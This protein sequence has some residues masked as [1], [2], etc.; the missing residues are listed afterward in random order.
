MSRAIE[1]A[2]S[3]APSPRELSDLSGAPAEER[4]DLGL[5]ALLQ[6]AQARPPQGDRPALH[7]EATGLAEAVAVSGRSVD[8][9]AALAPRPAEALG[10]LVLED[11]LDE[12]LDLAAGEGLEVLP[13][14]D[15]L[16]GGARIVRH[17]G[18]CPSSVC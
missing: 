6:A 10:H 8:G 12:R 9:G 2:E 7:R 16:G 14:R 13:G 1:A 11:P 4:Q 3:G 5:E 15:R 17:G 18:G